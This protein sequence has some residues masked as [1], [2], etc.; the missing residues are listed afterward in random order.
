MAACRSLGC[1]PF[2][3]RWADAVGSYGS[4]AIGRWR[5][6]LLLAA[7]LLAMLPCVG[8]LLSTGIQ[9]HLPSCRQA[10]CGHGYKVGGAGEQLPAGKF[11][12][13]TI[14]PQNMVMV[15]R[16]ATARA[17]MFCACACFSGAVAC[18]CPAPMHPRLRPRPG[19][20]QL[21]CQ[22]P[23]MIVVAVH[24]LAP[25]WPKQPA[26]HNPPRALHSTMR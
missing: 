18:C 24:R 8:K 25:I 16:W 6:L 10:E 23:P 4:P 3:G 9:P 15:S 1:R 11:E 22:L 2:P 13:A 17:G 14:Y 21:T 7:Q 19:L 5:G 26:H 12:A 20:L